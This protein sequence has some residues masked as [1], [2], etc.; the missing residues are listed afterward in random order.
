M[1]IIS[2]PLKHLIILELTVPWEEQIMETNEREYAQY[3]EL[4]EGFRSRNWRTFYE[5]IEV[6]H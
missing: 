4:V 2:E 6:G 3:E 5:P 1:I